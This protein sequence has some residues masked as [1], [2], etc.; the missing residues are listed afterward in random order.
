MDDQ[1]YLDFTNAD[2][3]EDELLSRPYVI[4][5][6]LPKFFSR[7]GQDF[8]IMTYI[9]LIGQNIYYGVDNFGESQSFESRGEITIKSIIDDPADRN[10][11]CIVCAYYNIQ[12]NAF[13]S[14]TTPAVTKYELSVTQLYTGELG[15]YTKKT[16][17]VIPTTTGTDS[18]GIETI[19]GL[20]L[21]WGSEGP[22]YKEINWARCNGFYKVRAVDQYFYRD[23][24]DTVVIETIKVNLREDRVRQFNFEFDGSD[25]LSM[26]PGR[27]NY[28]DYS[29]YMNSLLVNQQLNQGGLIE[30]DAIVVVSPYGF[31]AG[32]LAGKV[33]ETQWI[34]EGGESAYLAGSINFETMPLIAPQYNI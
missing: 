13:G 14:L 15:Q 22:D 8:T 24:D 4:Q 5:F 2:E 19:G 10:N 9:S 20:L 27:R 32:L 33:G 28:S 30:Q 16:I 1:I 3:L 29:V 6:R 12:E 7:D 17:D 31:K 23:G 26:R 21:N 18:N 25:P 34:V 11:Q